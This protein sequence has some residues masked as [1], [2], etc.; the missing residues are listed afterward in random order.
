[1]TKSELID[2]LATS[3][4]AK[5]PKKVTGEI[6]DRLSTVITSELNRT[7]SFTLPGVGKL[8]AVQREARV[9]RNPRTGEAANIDAKKAVKFKASASLKAAIQ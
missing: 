9:G 1:M 6:I 5:Y 4:S 7:G 3:G 8:V 2:A